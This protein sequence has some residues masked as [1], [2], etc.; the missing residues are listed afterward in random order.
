MDTVIN[1]FG[2]VNWLELHTPAGA[3]G[4]PWLITTTEFMNG[5]SKAMA[6]YTNGT[7]YGLQTCIR[8]QWA[9]LTL[10]AALMAIL[11]TIVKTRSWRS[12]WKSLALALLFHGLDTGIRERYGLMTDAKTATAQLA[13]PESGLGFILS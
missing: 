10:L 6:A 5:L 8:V 2:I 13:R 9:C 4:S 11:L 12:P 1:L 3:V 7:V